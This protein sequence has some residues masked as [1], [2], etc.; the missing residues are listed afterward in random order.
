MKLVSHHVQVV[1]LDLLA[2]EKR[3]FVSITVTFACHDNFIVCHS[4]T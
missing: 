3:A 4:N 2:Y 1:E